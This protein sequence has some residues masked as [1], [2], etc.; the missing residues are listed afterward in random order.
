MGSTSDSSQVD[1]L[2]SR[3]VKA[4]P[5][6]LPV[7]RDA[8]KPH[9]STLIPKLWTKLESAKP[10]D[11]TLL[12]VASALAVYDPENIKW[13]AVEGKVAQALVS[14]NSVFLG[15]WLE[16]LRSV[17]GKLTIP[18]ATISRDKGRTESE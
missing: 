7:L 15:M 13:K 11:V 18:L 2:F 8:L 9:S 10:G 16:A 3:L 6:E 17:R 14:V 5:S 1:Y 4:T 12:P